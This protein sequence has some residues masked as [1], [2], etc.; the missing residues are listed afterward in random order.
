[1]SVAGTRQAYVPLGGDLMTPGNEVAAV[2]LGT[3]T[4]T[5]IKVGIR[6]Q[7]IAVHPDVL[8]FV[9]N[10]YSNYITVIDPRIRQVM[11]NAEGPVEIKT[12]FYCTDLAF[13]PRNA[14]APNPDEQD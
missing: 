12:E 6:P 2:D 8:V 11:R 9:C 1:V 7:R 3:G 14:A 13:V 10:Q 5:R 4:V